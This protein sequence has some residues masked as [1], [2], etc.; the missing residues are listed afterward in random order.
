[1]TLMAAGSP[2]HKEVLMLYHV[3]LVCYA[4]KYSYLLIVAFVLKFYICH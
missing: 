1:M 3:I 4:T 2:S